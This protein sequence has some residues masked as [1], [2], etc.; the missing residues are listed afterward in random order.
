MD[1]T[2]ESIVQVPYHSDRL[3][4]TGASQLA[5]WVSDSLPEVGQEVETFR[6]SDDYCMGVLYARAI[7]T[8]GVR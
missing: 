5:I 6:R 8:G 7:K 2:I 4:V 1:C 3:Q